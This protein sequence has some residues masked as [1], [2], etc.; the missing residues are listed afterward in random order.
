[1]ADDSETPK[2]SKSFW[3]GLSAIAGLL[4]AGVAVVGLFLPEDKPPAPAA[5]GE[6]TDVQ[7]GSR[8]PCCTFSVQVV[9]NGYKGQDCLLRA[10]VINS[11]DD[12]ETAGGELTFIP[13]ADSDR[14][15]AD[16]PVSPPSTGT[17][18]ARFILYDPDG[19]ELDRANTAPFN[20]G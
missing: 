6:I 10:V 12:S 8:N 7:I 13:E 4:T 14:A 15:R 19:V 17:Y 1:M 9:L 18:T 3:I 2:R 16:A 5:L 11:V 20:V